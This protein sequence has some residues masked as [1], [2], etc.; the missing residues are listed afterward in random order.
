MNPQDEA[1]RD[2]IIYAFTK[3]SIDARNLRVEKVD[4]ALLV[5]GTVPV[6]MDSFFWTGADEGG[7]EPDWI[8]LAI[9]DGRAEI[10]N[11]GTPEASLVI[12]THHFPRGST[13]R[14]ED[15]ED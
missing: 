1:R 6:S 7:D 5:N 14:H 9:A 3:A 12:G 13:I 8:I 15:V 11:G 2:A 10:E 4:G